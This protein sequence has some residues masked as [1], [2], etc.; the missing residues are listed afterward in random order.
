MKIRQLTVINLFWFLAGIPICFAQETKQGFDEKEAIQTV[1]NFYTEYLSLYSKED[2]LLKTLDSERK[3]IL[4][5][6]CT[7]KLLNFIDILRI[8]GRLDW[9]PFN[10]AQDYHPDWIKKMIIK[11]ETKGDNIYSFLQWNPYD[12]RYDNI[13]YL[14]IVK[15]NEVY[16][17]ESL[18]NL[19][20]QVCFSQR[21]YKIFD[22]KEVIMMLTNFYREYLTFLSHKTHN[23]IELEQKKILQKYCTTRLIYLIEKL[24]VERKLDADPF[25]D[26][27]N[28]NPDWIKKM[29]IKK[30]HGGVNNYDFLQWDANKG[31][32]DNII[33][34]EIVK[35]NE[36]ENENYKIDSLPNLFHQIWSL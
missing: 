7:Q 28:Y 36:N 11:K 3:E 4:Q 19:T 20:Y 23:G 5:K 10:E 17:I 26:A 13:I 29:I 24:T 16:K 30:G 1:T 8:Q 21:A 31:R 6:Y 25:V 35:E 34:L 27:N 9:N 33:R 2:A 18:P 15:E 22:E 12:N 14:K 32:Y